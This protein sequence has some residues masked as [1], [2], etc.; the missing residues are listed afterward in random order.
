[1][2]VFS[3]VLI[4]LFDVCPGM[5]E[6]GAGHIVGISSFGGK[7]GMPI[8]SSYSAAKFAL[9]GL[10]ESLRFELFRLGIS[11]T[12]FCPG[13][14]QGTS[15]AQKGICVDGRLMGDKVGSKELI[16]SLMSGAMKPER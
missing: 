7:V 1:M 2:C 4:G 5:L 15:I 8:F 11:V 9:L 14:V 10:L 3:L 12:T 16:E 6:R 13:A